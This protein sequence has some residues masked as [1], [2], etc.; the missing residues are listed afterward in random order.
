MADFPSTD[1]EASG[2][3]KG[4]RRP[5]L[6]VLATAVGGLLVAG[7]LVLAT[8]VAVAPEATEKIY[9]E[10][11]TQVQELSR[12][13]LG[14]VEQTVT[15]QKSYPQIQLGVSGTIRELDRCDG[16]FTEMSSYE[17][18]GIPP[19]WAA[20]NNCG[21]DIILP[22]DVGTEVQLAGDPT[23]Y[24]IVDI[25]YTSKV[26][27]STDD[28]VGLQGELALQSCFYGEDRMKFIGLQ[29]VG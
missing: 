21:G 13:S 6:S 29:P 24:S 10:A 27:S 5:L 20:H 1:E 14:V 9:G 17:R 4:H 25:R 8:G 19:V 12:E 2:S 23:V 3:S 18:E 16:T 11:K 7:G 15:G 22:W 26:W 28:L